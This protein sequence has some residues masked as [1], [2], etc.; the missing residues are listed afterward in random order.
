[1]AEVADTSNTTPLVLAAD[2][3]T[4]ALS[5]DEVLN[6]AGDQN[7]YQIR[8]FVFFA[9]QWAVIAVVL[10]GQPFLFKPPAFECEASSAPGIKFP[11]EANVDNCKN[12]SLT[13]TPRADSPDTLVKTF[14]LYCDRVSY[15]TIVQSC[16]FVCGSIGIIIFSYLADQIGRFVILCGSFTLTAFMMFIA[17]FMTNYAIFGVLLAICGVGINVYVTLCFI[18]LAESSSEFF[19]Q[20]SNLLV[21]ICWALGE[22]LA[23]PL[24]YAADS[25]WRLLCRYCV[26][27]PLLVMALFYIWIYESPK[28]LVIRKRYPQAKAVLKKI[29]AANGRELPEFIFKESLNTGSATVETQNDKGPQYGYGDLFRYKSVRYSTIGGSFMFFTI[30][31][32]YYGTTFALTSLGGNIYV[33]VLVASGAELLA[34]IVTV[35]IATKLSRRVTFIA[36][37]ALSGVFAFSFFFLNIPDECNSAEATCIQKTLQTVFISLIRFGIS[38]PFALIYLYLNELFPTVVRSLGNGFCQM[39]SRIG[40]VLSPVVTG[41]LTGTSIS[42]MIPLGIMALL[43]SVVVIPMKETFGLPLADELEENVAKGKESRTSDEDVNSSNS[44]A[45]Y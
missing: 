24:A 26:G 10:M 25:D 7:K 36:S 4:V 23:A 35:P 44:S 29:A 20:I 3:S 39:M 9:L 40:S 1:M 16:F 45:H 41:V 21:L 32:V 18:A 5:A 28:F 31:F 19:R 33:N 8:M 15:I 11:C 12:S 6:L 30:Y 43:A 13:I 17:S 14:D 38:I 27:L 2:G 42:P 37:F 34:Y 22:M